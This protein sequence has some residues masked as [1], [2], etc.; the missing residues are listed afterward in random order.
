MYLFLFFCL[1]LDPTHFCLPPAAALPQCPLR[2]PSAHPLCSTL[3]LSSAS[4]PCC[5]PASLRCCLL[6]PPLPLY[7]VRLCRFLLL[8]HLPACDVR[9]CLPLLAL[10][11]LCIV[12]FANNFVLH[13]VLSPVY[14]TGCPLLLRVV[15]LQLHR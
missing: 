12:L 4:F 9:R 13:T 8:P 3:L 6:L 10:S 2:F 14:F 15:V 5:P 1:C 7:T 11:M